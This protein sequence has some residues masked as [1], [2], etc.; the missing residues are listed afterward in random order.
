[1]LM[2][3]WLLGSVGPAAVALPVEWAG[4]ALADAA[5]RWFKRL[6]RTDD[7]SRLLKAA[8]GASVS[9]SNVEFDALRRLLE[10]DQTWRLLRHG[11]VEALSAQIA[12]CLPPDDSR[13]AE[14]SDAAA[15]IIARGLLEFAVAD[16]DPNTFQQVLLARLSRMEAG[17]GTALDKAL[18]D[19]HAD[20]NTRFDEIMGQLKKVLD[21]LPPG[22]ANRGEITVYLKTI[23]D[24]LDTDLWP[25][26]F[27][28]RALTPTAI[29][30][31]LRVTVTG[32]RGEV[33]DA[34][35]LGQ[36]CQRLVILGRPGSGKTWL[37]KRI[38]RQ[39]ADQAYQDL[40]AGVPLDEVELPLFT[41]C[42]ALFSASGDVRHAVVSSALDQLPDLGGA[43]ISAA[44]HAFFTERNTETLLVIDSLDEASGQDQRRLREADTLPWR[45]ILTTRPSSWRK[46]LVIDGKNASHCVGELQPLRYPSDIEPFIKRWFSDQPERGNELAGQLAKSA[47]LQRAAT[48]PLILA[49]YC[50]VGGG[51]E[52]LPDL[53]RELIAKVLKR[54]LYGRWRNSGDRVPDLG[55]CLLTLQNWAWSAATS[56]PLTGVGTWVD[57]ITS[58]RV[59]IDEVSKGA[60][61][62]VAAP[63]GLPGFDT[64]NTVRRFVHRSIREHLVA[65]YI[66]DI[67]VAE[68]AEILLPHLWYDPDWEYSAPAALAMHP[69][70]DELLRDLIYRAAR[71]EQM[72]A[73]LSVLDAQWEFRAF[74]ARVAAETRE[75]D[76]SPEMSQVIGQAREELARSPR[77]GDLE[78]TAHWTHSTRRAREE[79]LDSLASETDGYNA[80]RLATKLLDLNPTEEDKSQA[81]NILLGL[82]APHVFGRPRRELSNAI[83]RL[84]ET[85]AEKQQARAAL[86]TLLTAETDGWIGAGIASGLLEIN[87]AANEKQQIRNESLRLLTSQTHHQMVDEL[88]DAIIRSTATAQD[89][90]EARD[91]LL[92]LLATDTSQFEARIMV[93]GVV[94]LVDTKE[95][96]KKVR[97]D[98]LGFVNGHPTAEKVW[99]IVEGVLELNPT[100][101]NK[102]QI[103]EVLLRSLP[104][105]AYWVTSRFAFWISHL[106]STPETESQARGILIDKLTGRTID[107]L[108]DNNSS[109]IADT[110]RALTYLGPTADDKR[111]VRN[112]LR[113]MLAG[114]TMGAI[115]AR[116]ASGILELDP[117]EQD[118]RL[119]LAAL[120][121][122]LPEQTIWW[123]ASELVR[124]MAQ[125]ITTA[126]LRHSTIEAVLDTLTRRLDPGVAAELA[127][128]V[129]QLHPTAQDMR[130]LREVLPDL[131]VSGAYVVRSEQL[132]TNILQ[133]NLTIREQGQIRQALLRL[134]AG[135]PVWDRAIR[136]ADSLLQLDPTGEDKRQACRAL[137]ITAAHE[138]N[139]TVVRELV[140]RILQLEPSVH[141]LSTWRTWLV[142]PTTDLIAETRRNT[143]TAD[144]LNSLS[145]LP[146]QP[147]R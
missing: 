73:D 90:R 111:Q 32:P 38:A 46:Q 12:S 64:G 11:T 81:R 33:L 100:A 78:G 88:V 48:V 69:Q 122:A 43:R 1:M 117:T 35:G 110:A 41:T 44:L 89:R 136:L 129:L 80:A 126:E 3:A 14:D 53:R 101:T 42:S 102:D 23:I 16:L 124:S 31:R 8:T 6:R 20:L 105:A 138:R 2:L 127:D 86:L 77:F 121:E 13:T 134:L 109:S 119:V 30:R 67:P 99:P 130:R 40:A 34:D 112:A 68:A 123:A 9:L 137:I 15:L 60:L 141:D 98:L 145:D 52:P 54:M 63:L 62:H 95:H 114:Q 113:D 85:E 146:P 24:W 27:G 76:W 28:A 50:I 25:Q 26:D 72:P 36:K 55:A 103:C 131:L 106:H 37:A 10:D 92:Q 65:Q 58:E 21:R 66:A 147:R 144:W 142:P 91:G 22:P 132:I 45:L 94:Q 125:L 96:E 59:D 19:L 39:R 83:V 84:A 56:H 87:P 29:E 107:W 79:L 108:T 135:N 49:C 118:K 139:G 97:E 82:L 120:I 133:L 70:H 140:N 61:D 18:L 116:L 128:G 51:D 75:G 17:Q 115:V 104:T 7:L 93:A 57:D 5:R 4:D 143:T 47:T 74:L 71:S